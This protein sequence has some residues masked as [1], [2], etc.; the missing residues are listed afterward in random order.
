MAL[1][2]ATSAA[3]MVASAVN[4]ACWAVST[5]SEIVLYAAT[6]SENATNA[7]STAASKEGMID[8]KVV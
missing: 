4:T 2:T 5:S 6:A 7:A 8:S 1:S 3:F